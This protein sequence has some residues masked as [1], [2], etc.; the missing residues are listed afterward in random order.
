MIETEPHGAWPRTMIHI[1]AS[2]WLKIRSVRSTYYTLAVVVIGVAGMAVLAWQASAMW[3][4]LSPV[5]RQH[6]GL[7]PLEPIITQIAELCL[8]ILGILA[9]TPEYATGMIRTSLVAVPQRRVMLS[10]KAGIVAA[11]GL[12][13]GL[14]SIFA[15]SLASRAIVGHRPI[16]YFMSPG[17]HQTS[18]L[19]AQGMSVIAFAVVGLSLGVILRSTIGAVV[20]VVLL[21]YVIPMVSQGL[22]APWDKRVNSVALDS[23]AG[24]IAGSGNANSIY[25][26]LLSP[27]A[28]LAVMIAYVVVPLAAAAAL[29]QR[30]DA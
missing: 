27:L 22:P 11:I 17:S 24:Q 8:A 28:A 21:L 6:F 1:L 29:I 23:L 7:S 13:A 16:R 10:A 12:A 3:D 15:T 20:C 25:G 26:S 18:L 2:E 9:I 19:L 14:T 4:R 5:D 30:R